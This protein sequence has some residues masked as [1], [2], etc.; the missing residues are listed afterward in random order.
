MQSGL[1]NEILLCAHRRS[2]AAVK[3]NAQDKSRTDRGWNSQ[4]LVWNSKTPGPHQICK[5][6][7]VGNT[8]VVS[9]P[10]CAQ[11]DR[12]RCTP[13]SLCALLETSASLDRFSSQNN[14]ASRSRSSSSPMGCEVEDGL[15]DCSRPYTCFASRRRRSSPGNRCRS[16]FLPNL[17]TRLWSDRK[18]RTTWVY[19]SR[20]QGAFTMPV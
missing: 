9:F 3:A 18:L 5:V 1:P 14:S 15:I 2:E 13:Y 19:T 11:R 17:T 8:H 16:K 12:W 4:H 7:T 20:L 6:V 10:C